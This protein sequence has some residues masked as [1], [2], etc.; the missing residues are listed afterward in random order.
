MDTHSSGAFWVPISTDEHSHSSFLPRRDFGFTH[1]QTFANVVL[2]ELAYLLPYY[3]LAFVRHGRGFIPVALL[4]GGPVGNVYLDGRQRWSVRYSPA[5]VRGYPF[6]LGNGGGQADVLGILSDHLCDASMGRP[7]FQKDGTLDDVV[8]KTVA[9]LQELK[10]QSLTT[11]AATH[12]LENMGLIQPWELTVD[13]NN[14]SVQLGGL[15]H[16]DFQRLNSLAPEQ[17]GSLQG[18]PLLLAYAQHLS[19]AQVPAFK[20]LLVERGSGFYGGAQEP[21][22][23]LLFGED[24]DILHF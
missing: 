14:T 19:E 23:D 9:F 20:A 7:L 24:A 15:Y 3:V 16:V 17:L 13:I 6:G 1:K 10:A 22:L 11:E 18:S 8:Q 5:S 21:D 4:G 2:S 12:Q